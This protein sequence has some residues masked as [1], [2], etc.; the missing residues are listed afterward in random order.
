MQKILEILPEPVEGQEAFILDHGK[1]ID[2]VLKYKDDLN[3]YGWNI[4]QF[5]KLKVGA[6]VLNRHPQKI[7]KDKKFEIYA[8][9]YVESISKPDEEGNVVAKISHAFNIVP[10]LKQGDSFLETFE[11]DSKTKKPTTWMHFWLQYGMNPISYTDFLNLIEPLNGVP[12]SKSVA[13]AEE[14]LSIL[15]A[16]E[17]KNKSGNKGFKIEF[18]EDDKMHAKKVRKYS[19]IAKKLDF[20]E[21]QKSKNEIG[22]IGEEIVFDM[23]LNEAKV[24]GSK[25]PIHVSKI[26]GDGL[27]YDIRHWDELDNEVHIEVKATKSNYIDGFEMSSNE[28][29][30]S[31]NLDYKYLIYRVYD[32]DI[33]SRKCKIKIYEGPITEDNYRLIETHVAVYQK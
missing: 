31:Q 21:I 32:L 18:T 27:G 10:P 19:G 13:I 24:L 20:D 15:E 25:Y 33:S 11:W 17:L 30:M 9:G 16:D 7:M 5:K 3:S 4:N 12:V 6:F 14:I 23:L 8:G 1:M 22:A 2:G 29:F 26:E 28:V